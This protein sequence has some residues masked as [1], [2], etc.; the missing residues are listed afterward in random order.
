V[1]GYLRDIWQLRFFWLALVRIDLRARY[2]R[3]MIGIGWSLLQ[4]IAMSIVLCTVFSQIFHVDVRT[5]GPF[6]LAGLTFWN[7]ITA[8]VIGGCQTFFQ[9]ES[10]IRQHPAPLAIYPLRVTLGAGFHFLL[11][12][13]VVL[14]ATWCL[15]GLQS[16]PALLSLLPT[17]LLLFLLGYSLAICAGVVN[18]MFQDTQHLVE[19]VLQV[20]FYLTPIIYS[21]KLLEERHVGSLVALNP[22]AAFLELIRQPILEGQ[23]PSLD[24]FGLATLFTALVAATATAVLARMERRMIFY[25]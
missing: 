4:P 6:L 13:G 21:I 24:A 22:L 8:V 25:L 15:T 16:L 11:G 19:V 20:L 5:Y 2:R 1:T 17:L 18:V 12:M 14:V 23:F 7:Y 3:S 9:S 10:Y